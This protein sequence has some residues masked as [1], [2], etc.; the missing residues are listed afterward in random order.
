MFCFLKISIK[1]ACK[2]VSKSSMSNKYV[3]TDS[4]GLVATLSK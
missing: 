1:I 3:H 2:N 4:L